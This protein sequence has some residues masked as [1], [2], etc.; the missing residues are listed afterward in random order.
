MS[1]TRTLFL[2]TSNGTGFVSDPRYT[3]NLDVSYL[4]MSEVDELNPT[5]G[6]IMNGQAGA[7]STVEPYDVKF[8]LTFKDRESRASWI[9][10]NADRVNQLSVAN[11]I[12]QDKL[13]NKRAVLTY[14][15]FTENKYINGVQAEITLKLFG[16]WQSSLV[17]K[18]IN[19]NT[20]SGGTKSYTTGNGYKYDDQLRYGSTSYS[21]ELGLNGESGFVLRATAGGELTLTISSGK[22]PGRT[23]ELES[24]YADII[25]GFSSDYVAYP[26]DSFKGL[27]ANSILDGGTTVS[28]GWEIAAADMPFLYDI[29]NHMD[30]YPISLGA[31][32]GAN[33][34]VPVTVYAY[35]TAD[36]I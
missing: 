32:N 30:T 26:V 23:I 2:F 31:V 14:F 12:N 21:S 18:I 1:D 27:A 15:Q 22:Y 10:A 24:R 13:Y 17:H 9:Q 28:Y 29:L 20:Y 4:D 35:S 8:V 16:R 25:T 33:V 5:R 19:K 6:A 7:I 3:G 36:F 11:T 34:P